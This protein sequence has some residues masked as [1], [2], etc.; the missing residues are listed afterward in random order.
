MVRFFERLTQVHQF[1][2]RDSKEASQNGRQP[3]RHPLARGRF[4]S[5]NLALKSAAQY[6]L[7]QGTHL[8]WKH[9]RNESYLNEDLK[10]TKYIL[11]L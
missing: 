4:P 6:P 1:M 5:R 9:N 10:A 11:Q 7:Y 2:E 3:A 8:P